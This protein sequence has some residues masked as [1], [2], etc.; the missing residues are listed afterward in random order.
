M[1]SPLFTGGSNIGAS[2]NWENTVCPNSC[3]A[4]WLAIC[5]CFRRRIY[6]QWE[7]W[8]SKNQWDVLYCKKKCEK[9]LY[10][11]RKES[12]NIIL[13]EL[14]KVSVPFICASHSYFNDDT[15]QYN[16]LI[17]LSLNLSSPSS[18]IANGTVAFILACKAKT[19]LLKR[20]LIQFISWLC[21]GISQ[22]LEQIST[23][24]SCI[25]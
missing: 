2:W 18:C 1:T 24:C 14:S 15:L 12:Q 17:G 13:D 5:L 22:Y 25:C 10:F 7:K 16:S 3:K 9:N 11:E 23:G 20:L 19:S 4:K 21:E 6:G 8:C